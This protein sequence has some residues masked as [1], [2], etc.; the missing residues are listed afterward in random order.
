MVSVVSYIFLSNIHHGKKIQSQLFFL[1]SFLN[2]GYDQLTYMGETL[3]YYLT[4]LS[5]FIPPGICWI[6]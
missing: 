5:M 6:R 3:H 4:V 1:L 2:V